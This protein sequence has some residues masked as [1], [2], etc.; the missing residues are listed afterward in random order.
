MSAVLA[1][2][3]W[4]HFQGAQQGSGRLAFSFDVFGLLALPVKQF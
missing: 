1:A 3:A 2:D 4:S